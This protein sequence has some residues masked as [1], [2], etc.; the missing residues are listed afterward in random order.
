MNFHARLNQT[1][2]NSMFPVT[3]DDESLRYLCVKLD[4]CQSLLNKKLSGF[5][6]AIDEELQ[7]IFV[8]QK[9]LQLD[10]KLNANRD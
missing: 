10:K 2:I 3:P 7:S 1:F 4:F 8:P 9:K 5:V 6:R